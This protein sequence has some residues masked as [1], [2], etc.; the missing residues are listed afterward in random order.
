MNQMPIL[1]VSDFVSVF[2]QIIEMSQPIVC[3]NGEISSFKISKNRWAYLDLKD[4]ASKVRCFGA[5]SQLPTPM[6]DGMLINIVAQPYLHPQYGFTL[7]I[8]SIELSGEGTL[9]RAIK[10]LEQKLKKE[11]LFDE[12]RKRALP[13]P[14]QKIALI[15]SKGSAAHKDFI[16]IV[17]ARWGG[18][19]IYTF[20][21]H[22][23]GAQA[24]KDVIGAIEKANLDFNFDL[25]VV[26]RGGGSA[27]DLQAFSNEAVVRA[28]ASSRTPTLVAIGHEVDV[29]LAER[30][31]DMRA[32]T[33]S[34][35][36][37]LMVPDKTAEL[38]R[39]H[40]LATQLKNNVLSLVSEE[41]KNIDLRGNDLLALMKVFIKG[42][43]E[44]ISKSETLL[45]SLNP[46]V[47]LQRGYA[48]VTKNHQPIVKRTE[49]NIGDEL[50]VILQ[51]W[52]LRVKILQ[53][54]RRD[55]A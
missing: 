3:V 27:D 24:V 6:E 40:S 2:N 42:R 18:L 50:R 36:A 9:N 17:N 39:V 45:A 38:R 31:A 34:N 43:E 44:L 55:D 23:Q 21:V 13:Y 4:Q 10:L 7:N 29:S 51:H 20:D 26:T 41:K 16:K 35:A 15:T 46:S 8:I 14:P 49:L 30:A 37:E 48:L 47:V 33:P 54:E 11:G 19:E 12:A 32:S 25:I 22:V 1:T 52:N 53:K 28:I 5:V